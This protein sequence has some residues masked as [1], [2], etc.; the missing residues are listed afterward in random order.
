MNAD[1][2]LDLVRRS[3]LVESDRLSR[4]VSP[5]ADEASTP[6]T[7]ERVAEFL[8]ESGVLTCWQ[9][10]K[11]LEGKWKGF[12]LMGTFKLLGLLG[13]GGTSCVYLGEDVLLARNV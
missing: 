7:A 8:V 3:G 1:E 9:A 13:V 10:A 5:M 2:F 6:L 12:Y 11:L 4:A